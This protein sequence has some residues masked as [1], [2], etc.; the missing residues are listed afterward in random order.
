LCENVFSLIHES[1][2]QIP[3]N[4]VQIVTDPKSLQMQAN[5]EL[6]RTT[7]ILNG[8]IVNP[9]PVLIGWFLTGF[10]LLHFYPLSIIKWTNIHTQVDKEK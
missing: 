3:S 10:S 6:Q 8:T 2:K 5:Q 1:K 9:Y 7:M 4:P